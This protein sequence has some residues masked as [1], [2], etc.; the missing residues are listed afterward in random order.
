V[1]H[2][3]TI[4][5][6]CPTYNSAQFILKTLHSVSDQTMYPLEL[7]ISDDGS[8]DETLAIVEQ[9]SKAN[10]M[11]N[12]IILKN[13]HQGPGAARNAGI[14]AAKGEWIAFLDSDDIWL[15][16]K[17]ER[18]AQVILERLNVNFICHAEENILLNG[19]CILCDYGSR[20][21]QHIKLIKQLY[22]NNLFSTSAVVCKKNLIV[23]HGYFDEKLMSAQDYELWL[24][25]AKDIHVHFI[26]EVLGSYIERRGN[27]SSTHFARRLKNELVIA[28]RYR[29][30]VDKWSFFYYKML[31]L[32]MSFILQY[33]KQIR[34]RKAQDTLSS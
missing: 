26:S 34:K 3:T 33:I 1:N 25:L 10:P 15:P 20:Y 27:I 16:N 18:V 22:K 9:F 19:K 11:L 30:H 2:S 13:L 32:C 29:H 23:R 28:L 5:V 21:S 7:I 12:I 4:S 8:T 24:R 17:I 6:I 31:R 14:K